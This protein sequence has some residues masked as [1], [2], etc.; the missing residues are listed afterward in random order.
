LLAQAAQKGMHMN[1]VTDL[2][3]ASLGTAANARRIVYRTVGR[4]H[5]GI[6]RLVS[7]GDL[8]Q[9]IKPFIFLDRFELRPDGHR[10]PM[11]PHSGIATVTV[12]LD[13][14][15]EYEETNGHK[16]VLPAGAVEWMN[17]GGGVWHGGAAVGQ[18]IVRG[19]QLWLALAPEDENG[20][21]HSRYLAPTEVAQAG[22]A[23]VVIGEY[24]GAAS[25]IR[26]RVPINYLSV[27]LAGG[28]RWTYTPPAGHDV[29]WVAV[30]D[31]L[32]HTAGAE[33]GREVAVFEPG[34]GTLE[35]VAEGDTRFVLGSAPRHPHALVSGSYS[36]HTSPA[37]LARGEAEIARIGARLRAA[38]VL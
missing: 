26:T 3:K 1:T 15:V 10:M 17:A 37:A 11:H 23:R 34:E 25:A 29:A 24:E 8:G 35:F 20:P 32:L 30:A 22:P 19:F 2:D 38:G 5:G 36:V 7:P 33:V 9:L 12:V 27:K 31:G 18:D 6:I 4:G 14:A 28:E 13:G 21:S 16:G